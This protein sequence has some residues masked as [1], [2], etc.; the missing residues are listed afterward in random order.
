M[1]LASSRLATLTAPIAPRASIMSR[2][3]LAAVRR[4]RGMP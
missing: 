4:V 2:T 3:R 1:P